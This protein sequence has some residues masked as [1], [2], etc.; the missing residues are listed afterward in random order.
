MVDLS[1]KDWTFGV[2][3]AKRWAVDTEYTDSITGRLQ[4]DAMKNF[5]NY[6]LGFRL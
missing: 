4:L 1:Y 5:D 3:G 6:S 2:T